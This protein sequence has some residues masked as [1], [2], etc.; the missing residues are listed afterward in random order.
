MREYAKDRQQWQR[1][2]AD[3]FSSAT[4]Q[5]LATLLTLL[6]K[7]RSTH[8]KPNAAETPSLLES[9][10]NQDAFPSN[11]DK[12]SDTY[13]TEPN[14][15]RRKTTPTNKHKRVRTELQTQANKRSRVQLSNQDAEAQAN[16]DQ[17]M[18]E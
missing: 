6:G 1:L 7:R 11:A 13:T 17:Q 8:Q 15:K 18:D 10:T 2:V 4:E 14:K 3:I 12:D 5:I 9:T 16:P